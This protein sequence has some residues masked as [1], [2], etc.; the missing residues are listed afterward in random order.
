MM[1][2]VCYRAVRLRPR[3]VMKKVILIFAVIAATLVLSVAAGAEDMTHRAV[4]APAVSALTDGAEGTYEVFDIGAVIKI[5]AD[6]PIAGVYIKF[7]RTP[8]EWL[9]RAGTVEMRCGRYG[10]L[11]EWCDISSLGCD[12]HEVELVFDCGAA[13]ICDIYVFSF[14]DIP[15]WVQ[16]WE[17]AE[18][19][20]DLMLMTTHADDEQLFFLGVLPYYAGELQYSVQVVYF[21]NHN[22]TRCRPHELLNGLWTVGVRRYPVIGGLPDYWDGYNETLEYSYAAALAEGFTRDDLVDFQ[23]EMLRRYRP[24]VVVGHDIDGEY[25]HPQ[26]KINT[27]TLIEALTLAA[28]PLY[29]LKSGAH[30]GVWDVPK[31][32]LHLYPENA[33]TM[34]WDVPLSKFDGMTAYEV[35][36]LGYACHLS[37]QY[38]WFTAW[39]NGEDVKY[40]RASEI[41]TYKPTDYGLYRS[42]VG[43]DIAGGDFFENLAVRSKTPEPSNNAETTPPMTDEAVT[44]VPNPVD[45]TVS[46]TLAATQPSADDI[47]TS[48]P[49]NVTSVAETE[50]ADDDSANSHSLAVWLMVMA[51]IVAALAAMWYLRS[52]KENNDRQS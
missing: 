14:G 22:N 6:E 3:C 43:T 36:K 34:N 16:R 47:T 44:T 50:D 8:P 30:L 11:H 27:D 2:E 12:A 23:T 31:T 49:A 4:I 21:T 38:T 35:S 10:F 48:V 5:R 39:I 15:D 18:G 17:P 26:H 24:Q 32:Y 25:G 1:G 41:S 51:V 13:E 28:D 9:L 52:K 33:I 42:L 40:T 46:E 37:Q 29:E 7:D 45:T 20:A 19:D